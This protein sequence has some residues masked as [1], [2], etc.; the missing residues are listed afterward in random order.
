MDSFKKLKNGAS[1]KSKYGS[2]YPVVVRPDGIWLDTED[3]LINTEELDP[4][5]WKEVRRKK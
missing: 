3:G 2:V 4:A 1:V 5:E